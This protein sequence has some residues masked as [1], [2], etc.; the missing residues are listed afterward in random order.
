MRCPG[1]AELGAWLDRE[2]G[3]RRADEVAQH[4]ASCTV[5]R[6][7]VRA[8]ELMLA[9]LAAP[10]AVRATP[11]M[12]RRTLARLNEAPRRSRR[13]LWLGAS[14]ALAAA[15]AVAVLLVRSPHDAGEFAARGGDSGSLAQQ[16]GATVYTLATRAT[17]L[18]A[19]AHVR[20][21]TAYVVGYRD[22]AETPV[23]TL[24]F[25]VDA[26]GD[27]HWL[28]PAYTAAAD[29]PL[30]APLHAGAREALMPDGVILDHPAPGPLRF[31]ALILPTRAS[32][33]AIEALHGEELTVSAL[34]ARFPAAV[35]SELRVEV[36]P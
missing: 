26:R 33:A 12:V 15:A 2:L 34:Q 36:E 22:L 11:D 5:C 28:Y 8:L 3:Q 31:V 9:E 29:V 32:V 10:A 20:A 19:G 1:T 27:V 21:D 25:A 24:T 4:V 30:A 16:V 6:P 14:G 13:G 23:W 7:A 18:A 17:P 35:I